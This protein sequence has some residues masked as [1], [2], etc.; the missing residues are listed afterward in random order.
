M[1]IP[2]MLV[3]RSERNIATRVGSGRVPPRSANIL[4]KIGTIKMSMNDA[5]RIASMRTTVG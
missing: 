2:Q 4:A 3:R 1:N 5:A